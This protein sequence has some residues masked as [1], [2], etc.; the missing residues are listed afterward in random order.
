MRRSVPLTGD[1]LMLQSIWNRRSVFDSSFWET[2]TKNSW[3][4]LKSTLSH[5]TLGACS[6]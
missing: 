6:A 3:S 4:R 5:A 1:L 2:T